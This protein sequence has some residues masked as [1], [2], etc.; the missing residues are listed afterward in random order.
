MCWA[1]WSFTPLS[2]QGTLTIGGKEVTL[3]YTPCPEFW[4]CKRVSMCSELPSAS[5][6][7]TPGSGSSEESWIFARW[8]KS[9][10]V[11]NTCP[12]ALAPSKLCFCLPCF[13][14]PL[15]RHVAV[16]QVARFFMHGAALSLFSGSFL[17]RRENSVWILSP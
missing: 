7:G 10:R 13:R 9:L 5:P 4:R 14:S 2:Q 3:E 1:C 17:K 12:E 8:P 6:A 11:I 16:V 15:C